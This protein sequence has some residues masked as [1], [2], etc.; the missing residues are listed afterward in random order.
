M[1]RR[2]KICGIIFL[3]L[4]WVA[5]C[6]SIYFI[7]L[8]EN[9]ALIYL[10]LNP[11]RINLIEVASNSKEFECDGVA[12]YSFEPSKKSMKVMSTW[13]MLPFDEET[14]DY[15]DSRLLRRLCKTLAKKR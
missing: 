11:I 12:F 13:D 2:T 4:L 5:I 9:K 6:I 1:K 15:L 8:P 7:S 14:C 3:S 10:G